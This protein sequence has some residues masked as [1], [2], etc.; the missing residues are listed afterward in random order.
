LVALLHE[1]LFDVILVMAAFSLG[2]MTSLVKAFAEVSRFDLK[3][4]EARVFGR[5][6]RAV[7]LSATLLFAALLTDQSDEVLVGGITALLVFNLASLVR[8]L[9]LVMP[10]IAGPGRRRR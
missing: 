10:V 8:R 2:L 5:A 3:W 9:T 4:S 7:L 6:G 1:S